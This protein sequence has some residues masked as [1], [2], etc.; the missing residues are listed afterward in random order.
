[1]SLDVNHTIL[2]SQTQR[3]EK[4]KSKL[5][6]CSEDFARRV[7]RELVNAA[8][9]ASGSLRSCFFFPLDA[10]KRHIS[11]AT[12]FIPL[13]SEVNNEELLFIQYSRLIHGL[14]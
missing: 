2:F 5:K 7:Y 11:T 8:R 14:T 13:A 9:F 4:K 3:Y 10:L 12:T 1:M 6:T